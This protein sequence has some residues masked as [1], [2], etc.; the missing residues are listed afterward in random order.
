MSHMA[1]ND[2]LKRWQ[3][4][5]AQVDT[6]D[7]TDWSAFLDAHPDVLALADEIAENYHRTGRPFT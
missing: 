3:A 5:Q 2:P 4:A 6:A 7:D 1:D